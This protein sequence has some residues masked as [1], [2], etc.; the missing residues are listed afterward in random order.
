MSMPTDATSMVWAITIMP[1][2]V[3]P[4]FGVSYLEQWGVGCVV[5]FGELGE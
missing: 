3:V 2:L 1:G 4:R 5:D